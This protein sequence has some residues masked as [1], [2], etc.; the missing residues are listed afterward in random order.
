MLKIN[1]DA[2]SKPH[3]PFGGIGIV[4][5]ENNFYQQLSYPVVGEFSNHELE[6]QAVIY[7]LEECTRLNLQ[8]KIIN[9]YSDS[10]IVVQTIE[11]NYTSNEIFNKYLR[12]INQKLQSFHL[13]FFHWISDNQNKGADNLARQGLKKAL[14]NRR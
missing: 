10:K 8:D 12:V 9:I 3:T 13:V 4:L 11:K 2:A 7:A 5:S 14:K 6:F 1:I